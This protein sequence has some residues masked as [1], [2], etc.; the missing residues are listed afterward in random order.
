MKNKIKIGLGG[1]CHWC[2]EGIFRSIKGID[3]VQQGWIS[4]EPPYH[5]FSE[6]IIFEFDQNI[7][8]LNTVLEIHLLTHSSTSSHTL[9]T[10]YRS[11]IYI[12]KDSHYEP[13]AAG[14]RQ[15]SINLNKDFI[16]KI[17]KF[18]KFKLNKE[19]QL[20]YFFTRP[21][22]PFC[23][24]YIIPKLQMLLSSH[25]HFMDSKSLKII[26]DEK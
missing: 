19:E 25:R 14:L 7:I 2:T 4:G 16:T 15:L 6:G 10:K 13:V 9:R 22:A 8:P 20:N 24:T 17:I 1:G 23:K 26:E 18:K 11:A 3:N 12:F 21:Q 5:E